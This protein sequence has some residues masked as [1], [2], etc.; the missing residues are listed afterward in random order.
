LQTRI[1]ESRLPL[2]FSIKQTAVPAGLLIAGFVGPTLTEWSNWR[3]TM[4]ISALSCV[5]FSLM[6]QPRL[7]EYSL[8]IKYSSR[9]RSAQKFSVQA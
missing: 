3:Y 9:K 1:N 7:Q 2:I 6:L 5:I 8:S 4:L